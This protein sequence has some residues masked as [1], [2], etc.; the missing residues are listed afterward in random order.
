M[1]RVGWFFLTISIILAALFVFYRMDLFTTSKIEGKLFPGQAGVADAESLQ[2]LQQPYFYLGKG[3]QCFAFVSQDGQHV[4]KFL[5]YRRYNKPFWVR[6]IPPHDWLPWQAAIEAHRHKRFDSVVNGF[7]LGMSRLREE[8]GLEYIHFQRG[9]G[10]PVL[11]IFDEI[12]RIHKIDLNGVAFALQRKATP[13]FEE[14]EWRWRQSGKEGLNEAMRQYF[15][16]IQRRCDLE[17]SDDAGRNCGFF[18]GRA[19]L[20]DTGRIS[21]DPS[22][23][24]KKGIDR[25]MKMATKKLRKWLQARHPE[26]VGVIDENLHQISCS[27]EAQTAK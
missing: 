11:T 14:L 21:H 1:T 8:T 27:F 26:A 20:I 13:L 16:L 12:H 25:E 17:I 24:S 5:N 10:L 19:V 7:Q 3:R 6:L 23:K 9:E 2:N 22:L 15:A 18:Q 4:I